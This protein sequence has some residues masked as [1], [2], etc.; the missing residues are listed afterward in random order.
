MLS[1]LLLTWSIVTAKI[2]GPSTKWN[3]FLA[4][5]IPVDSLIDFS[6]EACFLPITYRASMFPFNINCS[7]TFTPLVHVLYRIIIISV[8]F[9]SILAILR[10]C[11]FVYRTTLRI[12]PVFT[13]EPIYFECLYFIY[14][15]D[16]LQSLILRYKTI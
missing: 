3:S 13:D 7:I 6:E 11:P 5:L 4:F 1:Q 2:L 16:F 10:T 8:N 9:S 12:F 15:W 14:Y